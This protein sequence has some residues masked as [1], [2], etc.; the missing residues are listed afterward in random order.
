MR[1]PT[2]DKNFENIASNIVG[3]SNDE[4]V[5]ILR[6]KNAADMHVGNFEAH[7]RQHEQE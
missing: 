3:Y 6:R 4:R 7:T 1:F 2:G 5:E